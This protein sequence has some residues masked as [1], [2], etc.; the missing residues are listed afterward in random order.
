MSRE[1]H[2]CARMTRSRE[3]AMGAKTFFAT[4]IPTA[5]PGRWIVIHDECEVFD[6]L[7]LGLNGEA[8]CWINPPEKRRSELEYAVRKTFRT[9]A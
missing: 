1:N 6:V 2:A 5:A 7:L 4:H 8:V 3:F 9:S